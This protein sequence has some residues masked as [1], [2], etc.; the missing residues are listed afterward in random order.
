MI[1]LKVLTMIF[2]APDQPAVLIL[3]PDEP[4]VDGASRIVPIWIGANEAMQLGIALEGIK[5]PRPL[6]HDL[7]LNAIANLD[8]RIENVVISAVMGQTFF[9]KL[10]LR[11]GGRLIS[12]DTRPTDA[13]ALAI[14]EGAPFYIEEDVLNTASF[15]FIFKEP[16]NKE[17]ELKEFHSFIENLS[18]EDLLK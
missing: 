1:Q 14:R 8:A 12:L 18:P 5:P 17:L 2:T 3:E 16:E 11:Q 9:A 4:A 13:L 10:I 15:P 7:F 6:T